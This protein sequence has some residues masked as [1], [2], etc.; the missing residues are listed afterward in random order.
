MKTK[1][2]IF[3]VAKNLF[4]KQGIDRTS[5][6][7]IAKKA[8]INIAALNYHY[9]SKENLVDIIFERIIGDF[10]PSLSSILNAE[11]SLDNKIKKYISTLNDLLIKYN[12]HLPFF[13]MQMMQRNP[14]KIMQL[15]FVRQLYNPEIFFNQIKREIEKGIIKPVNPLDFFMTLLS[16]VGFP[17]SMQYVL[18]GEY[19][20][21]KKD[22]IKFIKDREPM[23]F[24]ILM[25]QLKKTN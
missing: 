20:W 10:T 16:L 3:N 18:Q 23:I 6:K 24:D 4:F 21:G 25:N 17:F 13:I 11:D 5:V 22:F 2:K 15:K 1:E 9:K 8:D 7:E 19:Q 14:K 12:P